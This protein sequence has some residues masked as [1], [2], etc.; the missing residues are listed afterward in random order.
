M[1]GAKIL[2]IGVLNKQALDHINQISEST[3][4]SPAQKTEQITTI[5]AMQTFFTLLLAKNGVDMFKASE[6][7]LQQ[8]IAGVLQHIKP[9]EMYVSTV[10]VL[11]RQQVEDLQG[12]FINAKPNEN[13]VYEVIVP[14]HESMAITGPPSRIAIV[15]SAG[16]DVPRR[17]QT[18]IDTTPTEMKYRTTGLAEQVNITLQTATGIRRQAIGQ[19]ITNLERYKAS[20]Q[21][22]FY[23]GELIRLNL[24]TSP[25][26]DFS[27]NLGIWRD[28][29]DILDKS[30]FPNMEALYYANISPPETLL[31][32]KI[33]LNEILRVRMSLFER[34]KGST[35]F[36]IKVIPESGKE[37]TLFRGFC[38][39]EGMLEGVT[40]EA[41]ALERFGLEFPDS[42]FFKNG[43]PV[44]NIYIAE[45][46]GKEDNIGVPIF[47]G[48]GGSEESHPFSHT[49]TGFPPSF[50]RE[51]RL[52]DPVEAR[53]QP[54]PL[55][56]YLKRGQK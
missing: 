50:A 46:D 36:M 26:P 29:D 41:G 47:E 33:Q 32:N 37:R 22:D 17:V 40:T 6:M 5:I 52:V 45:F 12:R 14:S 9:P 44:K 1:M 8:P 21:I 2:G 13:G 31:A 43:E 11:T 10:S 39:I 16:M 4:L 20:G 3:S 18:I 35:W 27:R 38:S 49:G 55:L 19:T 56:D 7:A 24:L 30:V 23:E 54:V 42:P 15:D 48:F 25:A 53:N 34:D 51:Y 28:V